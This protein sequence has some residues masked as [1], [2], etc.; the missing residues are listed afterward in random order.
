MGERACSLVPLESCFRFAAGGQHDRA[1]DQDAAC[2]LNRGDRF[3][4]KERDNDR[5]YRDQVNEN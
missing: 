2:Y 1:D 3:V 5:G 4:K